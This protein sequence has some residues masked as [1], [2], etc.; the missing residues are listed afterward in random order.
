MVRPSVLLPALAARAALAGCATV[1]PS[2]ASA[3]DE[4]DQEAQQRSTAQLETG[5]SSAREP[6]TYAAGARGQTT[7]LSPLPTAGDLSGEYAMV[8]GHAAPPGRVRLQ[9]EGRI[10][11][12][13]IFDSYVSGPAPPPPPTEEASGRAVARLVLEG[14]YR[15]ESPAQGIDAKPQ[16]AVE[17]VRYELHFD[18]ESSRLI[19]TRNGEPI[20]LAP[21]ER[22]PPREKCGP[23]PP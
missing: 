3:A 1:G 9:R 21:F 23:P 8:S 10:R 18:S 16:R 13:R 20:T 17:R 5:R 22:V 19:G 7:P 2:P 12:V 4:S 15:E 14:E 6:A 11:L